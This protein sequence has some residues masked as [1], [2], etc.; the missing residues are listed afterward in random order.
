[1]G[2]RKIILKIDEKLRTPECMD[3][4][5][6][7]VN[8]VMGS[9]EV[10]S[11]ELFQEFHNK[12][13]ASLEETAKRTDLIVQE[14]FRKQEVKEDAAMSEHFEKQSVKY[15][16]FEKK[17][18]GLLWKVLAVVFGIIILCSGIVAATWVT[19]QSKADKTEVLLLNEAKQLEKLRSSYMDDRFVKNPKMTVDQYNYQW[20][21]ESIFE[22]NLRSGNKIVIPDKK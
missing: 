6:A 10:A 5:T 21:V 19:V 14:H 3:R 2:D 15:D 8:G 13:E 7:H 4:I 11:N 20:L 12:S 16:N 22:K 17:V 9:F 18:Y 1:M